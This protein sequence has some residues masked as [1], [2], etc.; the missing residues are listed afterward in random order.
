MKGDFNRSAVN[1]ILSMAENN[2]GENSIVKQKKVYHILVEMLQNIAKHAKPTEE[3]YHL[4]LFSMGLDKDVYTVSATNG[5]E[6]AKKVKL[7][8]YIKSLNDKNKTEL[9]EY[10]KVILRNGHDDKTIFSGLGLIDIARDSIVKIDYAFQEYKE[11]L[12]LFSL[13]AKV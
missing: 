6:P 13:T 7:E 5:I 8:N 11:N 4:G 9:D 1:P 10:Y 2:F 12:H 3:G